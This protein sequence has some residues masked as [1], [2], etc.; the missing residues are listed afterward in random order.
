MHK[1]SALRKEGKKRRA[2]QLL[3]QLLNNNLLVEDIL[4]QLAENAVLDK[5]IAAAESWYNILQKDK[6]QNGAL[7]SFAPRGY[8]L[9]L[10]KVNILKA[11]GKYEAA[12]DLIDNHRTVSEK[13]PVSKGYNLK[14]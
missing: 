1:A 13:I 2:E 8:R 14:G 11:E 6:N 4:F 3:R 12:L 10:L 5:N 9:L 7:F